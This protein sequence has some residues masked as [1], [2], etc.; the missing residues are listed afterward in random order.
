MYICEI[1][2]ISIH[3]SGFFFVA[4][5]YLL[6]RKME[7]YAVL[8]SENKN[9]FSRTRKVYLHENKNLNLLGKNKITLP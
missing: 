5:L 8:K 4:L 6:R 9:I 3:V 1:N 7:L 2:A